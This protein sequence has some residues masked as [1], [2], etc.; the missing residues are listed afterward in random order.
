MYGS[1]QE[2]NRDMVVSQQDCVG[3]LP[4]LLIEVDFICGCA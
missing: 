3:S 4:A 1:P 2:K